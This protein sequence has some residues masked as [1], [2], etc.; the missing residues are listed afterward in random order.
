MVMNK[1]G[2]GKGREIKLNALPRGDVLIL[3]YFL[4]LWDLKQATFISFFFG[5]WH[6]E[7]F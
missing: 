7:L 3:V 4:L 1:S 2:S 6:M 5:I